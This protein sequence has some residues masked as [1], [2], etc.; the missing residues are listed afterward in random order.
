MKKKGE[1]KR[2]V[3]REIEKKEGRRKI[4]KRRK[5]LQ[6]KDGVK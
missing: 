2:Y 4:K 6:K 1:R 5:K 3:H